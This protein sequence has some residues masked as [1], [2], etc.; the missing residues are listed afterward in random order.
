[1]AV[2]K[3]TLAISV[4]VDTS[5]FNKWSK[6]IDESFGRISDAAE[7]SNQK[8][9]RIRSTLDFIKA[10]MGEIARTAKAMFE[11][12]M[13]TKAFA[14]TLESAG[15]SIE[16][17][18]NRIS[19][20]LGSESFLKRSIKIISVGF[21][22][23]AKILHRYSISLS[24]FAVSIRLYTYQLSKMGDPKIVKLFYQ[25]VGMLTPILDGISNAID[26]TGTRIARFGVFVGNLEG[27]IN[28]AANSLAYFVVS[29]ARGMNNFGQT[30]YK[31]GQNL[32][33]FAI[34]YAKLYQTI[35]NN[36]I[37]MILNFASFAFNPF[38]KY[39]RIAIASLLAFGIAVA[40]TA[41]GLL[42]LGPAL[43]KASVHI[44]ETTE[45]IDKGRKFLISFSQSIGKSLLDAG[46]SIQRFGIDIGNISGRLKI[47]ASSF[48]EKDSAIM[49]SF[50]R[51]L[52]LAFTPLV[53]KI[54]AVSEGMSNFAG[55]IA[56]VG[57]FVKGFLPAVG[58]LASTFRFTGTVV[59]LVGKT[60]GGFGKDAKNIINILT[61]VQNT[62]ITFLQGMNNISNTV[63]VAAGGFASL[64]L[65]LLQSDGAASK[66]AGGAAL[67][68]AVAIGG[69]VS[70]TKAATTAIGDFVTGVGVKLFT[71]FDSGIQLAAE[72]EEATVRFTR[73]ITRLSG[74][75]SEAQKNISMWNTALVDIQKNSS[76][77]ESDAQAFAVAIAK[78]GQELNLTTDQQIKLARN[79]SVFAVDQEELVKTTEAVRL[80]LLGNG[81][82]AEELGIHLNDAAINTGSYS[83]TVGKTV[84]AMSDQERVTARLI[85]INSQAQRAQESFTSSGESLIDVSRRIKVSQEEISS[86]FAKSS[87]PVYK[88][89]TSIQLSLLKAIEGISQP[90]KTAISNIAAYAGATLIVIGVTV[91]WG[92]TIGVL[93][94]AVAQ[95]NTLIKVSSGL[96]ALL[97]TAFTITN[98]AVGQQVVAINGLSS[99]LV[100]MANFTKGILIAS[101]TALGRALMTVGRTILMV[102]TSVLTNPL[103]WK[104]TAVVTAI[105]AV[106][107]AVDNLSEKSLFLQ[108]VFSKTT[109]DIADSTDELNKSTSIWDKF[110]KV[111]ESL[112]DKVVSLAEFIIG[113]LLGAVNMV[114]MGFVK[115]QSV[116]ADGEDVEAYELMMEQ[117]SNELADTSKNIDNASSRL[118]DFGGKAYAATAASG[119]VSEGLDKIGSSSNKTATKLEQMTER[120][121]KTFNV[122]RERL[123]VLGD[124]YD[125][126]NIRILE[127]RDAMDKASSLPKD[128]NNKAKAIAE[129]K[130]ELIKAEI[131]AEKTRSDLVT[132]MLEEQNKLKIDDLKLNG[133]RIQAINIEY[134]QKLQALQQE[135]DGLKKLGGLRLDEQITINQTFKALKEAQKAE[136]YSAKIDNLKKVKDLENQ[137]NKI[138]LEGSKASQ[139]QILSI[140]LKNEQLREEL[141]Q[142]YKIAAATSD[143]KKASDAILKSGYQALDLLKQQEIA[144]FDNARSVELAGQVRDLDKAY[145]EVNQTAFMGIQ[146][147]KQAR[148]ETIQATQ[149]KMQLDGRLLDGQKQQLDMQRSIASMIA[150]KQVAALMRSNSLFGEQLQSLKEYF[151]IYRD[152]I[153][154]SA[155]KIFDGLEN[156]LDNSI[157]LITRFKSEV[158]E[159]GPSKQA[160]PSGIGPSAGGASAPA[161]QPSFIS[162]MISKG[163]EAATQAI[164]SVSSTVASMVPEGMMQI[165]SDIASTVGEMGN[166]Y[167]MIM[168]M[169]INAPAIILSAMDSM[170]QVVENLINFPENLVQS[171]TKLDEMLASFIDNFPQAM[172]SAM[173]KVPGILIKIAEKIP[174]FLINLMEE[175]PNIAEKLSEV[176]PVILAK[177]L[178][179]LPAIAGSFIKAMWNMTVGMIRGFFKGLGSVWKGEMPKI[180]NTDKMVN[181]IKKGVGKLTE[182]TDKIFKVGDITEVAKKQ[183]PGKNIAEAIEQATQRSSNWLSNAWKN[184]IKFI[185]DVW[186]FIYDKVIMPLIN[187]LRAIWIWIYDRVIMPL[188]NGIRAVWLFI[189]DKVILPIIDGIRAVWMFVYEKV[190]LPLIDGISAVFTFIWDNIL[191][192]FVDG[193]TGIFTFIWDN[194]LK[195][196]VEGIGSIFDTIYNTVFKPFIDGTQSFSDS[197]STNVVE[198]I[199]KVFE[200]FTKG[201]KETFDAISDKF[202]KWI[203][204]VK[205]AFDTVGKTVSSWGSK[206]WDG[207]SGAVGNIAKVFGEWGSAI[208]NGFKNLIGGTFSGF[209]MDI[210]NGLKN[211]LGTIGDTF[212]KLGG[213]IFDGLKGGIDGIGNVLSK[214]FSF[215]GGGKGSVEKFIGL[216]FPFVSFAQGGFVPGKASVPGDSS[217]NDV[218]PALL[219]P[220]EFVLP[221]GVTEDAAFMRVVMA[222]MEG[223][224]VP[225]FKLGGWIGKAVDGG[226]KAIGDIGGGI[227]AVAGP[228][229]ENLIPDYVKD[230]YE[231][232]NRF[233]SGID[234][235]KLLSDPKGVLTDAIKSNINAFSDS[236]KKMVKPTGFAEGGFVTGPGGVDNIPAMLSNG[237][238]VM[239]RKAVDAIGLPALTAMNSGKQ[240]GGSVTNNVSINLK[241]EAKDKIDEAFVKQRLMPAIREEL[242]R[243]SLDG[244]AIVYGSGVRK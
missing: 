141:N 13:A 169:V 210:F 170:T 165:G 131:D 105:A 32:A 18:G 144:R 100:N 48:K 180:V 176:I 120:I 132:R 189:Y 207:L 50:A 108:R 152:L 166:I 93:A 65:A 37:A 228:I 6:G 202:N 91:K 5:D 236:F 124:D 235:T 29:T 49:V 21:A 116:F 10:N 147:E 194:I 231:S 79:I 215:D 7:E 240:I 54:D 172:Q 191:K 71:L 99:V 159:I 80:A 115:I 86:A 112:F 223:K 25:S 38:D 157:K 97:T 220:G 155:G 101:L 46:L 102:T 45:A 109:K 77:T 58:E 51:A 154:M 150:E 130:I 219:S 145:R 168:K 201:A 20:T 114:A 111:I 123:K 224:E 98:T 221:R 181:D 26:F 222:K 9:E 173:D 33:V 56:R 11:L 227:S 243:N 43:G 96:Q 212:S 187:G 122:Q 218:I 61:E 138:R 136:V 214:M 175:L 230:L 148:L 2:T 83:E 70:V 216:D 73:S 23:I 213:K 19:S 200:D 204:D 53:Q 160:D 30:L 129:A 104:T 206:I 205:G 126:A 59:N 242:K 183:D 164:D 4:E 133:K 95:L 35:F 186:L 39:V 209:G 179:K 225:Q 57:Q 72:D 125:R 60:F 156:I 178:D 197:F 87:I 143:Q 82:A 84:D 14:D 139:D 193:V 162:S 3:E 184:L 106:I 195:P 55:R 22:D 167:M 94:T 142:H 89:F 233:I 121:L 113:G 74:S 78:L 238:F 41:L 208:W 42:K 75:F 211:A 107:K 199:K 226:S 140:S 229:L 64:G 12:V 151:S 81:R 62:Q 52:G 146:S 47:F 85:A 16:W 217:A 196:F 192:P 241:I 1:M 27:S 188:I 34:K 198:P 239:N 90:I 127:A 174:D 63:S 40:S 88:F 203:G 237:E 171:L 8:F 134:G 128:D 119:S 69:L 177:I 24:N 118:F 232:V 149:T 31:S 36:D 135:E 190:I 163:A 185:R 161:E 17:L 244:R 28:T 234:L 182:V 153:G 67:T 137:V 158:K 44:F 15:E 103:F 68:M 117:L 66:F 76:V 92:F 110:G